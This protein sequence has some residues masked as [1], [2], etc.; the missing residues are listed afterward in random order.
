LGARLVR[1]RQILGDDGKLHL[2]QVSH[3]LFKISAWPPDKKTNIEH[4]K[5]GRRTSNVQ[6]RMVNEKNG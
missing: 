3:K 1:F 2:E 4:W 5:D 6:H